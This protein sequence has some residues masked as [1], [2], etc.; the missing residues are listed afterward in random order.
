MNYRNLVILSWD[1]F[2]QP[3]FAFNQKLLDSLPESINI[4]VFSLPSYYANKFALLQNL[5]YDSDKRVTRVSKKKQYMRFVKLPLERLRGAFFRY[6]VYK[7]LKRP[8]ISI[9]DA[10]SIFSND[11]NRALL[12]NINRASSLELFS[13][14]LDQVDIGAHLVTDMSLDC[15]NVSN[16]LPSGSI[17]LENISNTTA[18]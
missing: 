13:M 11:G 14:K 2:Y 16:D 5:K 3:H 9:V 15:K 4:V 1:L 17:E 12:L 6:S 18:E 8:N 7:S 10:A